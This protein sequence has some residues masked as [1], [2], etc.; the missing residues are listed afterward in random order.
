IHKEIYIKDR[1]ET[2][3]YAG[4]HDLTD[5]SRTESEPTETEQWGEEGGAVRIVTTTAF[6]EPQLVD[7]DELADEVR[8]LRD[9]GPGEA[10]AAPEPAAAESDTVEAELEKPEPA[11]V[12]DV[13]D[14]E[15]AEVRPAETEDPEE[16]ADP[17]PEVSLPESEPEP[18][19]PELQ[20]LFASLREAP[21][22]EPQ[23]KPAEKSAD[24]VAEA[25]AAEAAGSPVAVAVASPGTA[26][27]LEADPFDVRDR[28][29]LPIE[30]RTLRSVKRQLLDLQNRVLEDLR[31]AGVGDWN[32]EPAM[33]TAAFSDDI[34][35]LVREAVVAGVTGAAEITGT[36]TPQ[37]PAPATSDAVSDFVDGLLRGL[38]NA[39]GDAATPGAGARKVSSAVS[40]VF[41]AWRTDEAE[42]RLRAAARGAYHRGVVA[43]LGSLGV[44][45]VVA[46]ES[47]TP[48]D[49]CP[50]RDGLA[51][52]VGDA[53]PPG[54]VMPPAL[55]SCACTV[56]PAS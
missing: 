44:S 3:Q 47:G 40:K 33:F 21:E 38:R 22:P 14:D 45:M 10:P 8:R 19:S 6:T 20:A 17:E 46:V 25:E 12:A 54:T 55:A 35:G 30:N 53:P 23:P 18:E 56:V 41:R 26:A 28:L 11:P 50:A 37:P 32:P 13:A 39:H 36:M 5:I 49:E 42:R 34:A 16:T 4:V 29:L 2:L 52:A 24:P 1:R 7:A 27:H 15:P 9:E 48:C 51:W 43:G 31:I